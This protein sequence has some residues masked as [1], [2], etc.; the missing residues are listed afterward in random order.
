[1]PTIPKDSLILL[2][3]LILCL[4]DGLATYW[5]IQHGMASELNPVMRVAF[6][7]MGPMAVIL[8]TIVT[9]VGCMFLLKMAEKG[10]EW[11]RL[12]VSGVFGVYMILLGIH[13]AI[14]QG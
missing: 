10:F 2:P 5:E 11:C 4:F 1:M 9:M 13:I 8:K 7:G 12:L 6:L 3:I 14:L